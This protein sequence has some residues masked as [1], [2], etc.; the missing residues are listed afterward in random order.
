MHRQLQQNN[1]QSRSGLLSITLND[2]SHGTEFLCRLVPRSL[3]GQ[4]LGCNVLVP[5]VQNVLRLDEPSLGGAGGRVC[6]EDKIAG[7][8]TT[9]QSY[10][11]DLIKLLANSGPPTQPLAAL[12]SE[13]CE[14]FPQPAL[15]AAFSVTVSD[16]Q[17][18]SSCK[19]WRPT[20]R[21]CC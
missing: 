9:T 11:L 18:A 14:P 3:Q 1:W 13:L 8:D 12:A 6:V 20:A 17:L 10:N 21:A 2:L 16:K 5:R 19:Q 7:R 15:F 4:H